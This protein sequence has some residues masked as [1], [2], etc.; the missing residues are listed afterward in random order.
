[1]LDETRQLAVTPAGGGVAFS[2][3]FPGYSVHLY[4]ITY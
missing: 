3:D 4:R 2:D 1:V